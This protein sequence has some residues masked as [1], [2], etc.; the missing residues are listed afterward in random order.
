MTDAGISEITCADCSSP[1]PANAKFCLE[2][3]TPVAAAP[4]RE[5]RKTVTLLF[6]DVT[7][8][9]AM[10]EALDPETYRGVMG[11]YF[12]V[13]RTAVERH[14]GTVEKF[15]GDAV[16]AVF[17]VPDV[18]EDDALRAVR[19]ADELNAAIT[20]LSDELPAEPR[21]PLAIRT[22][23]NTGSVVAG[24]ARA[25]GS[26]ATGDAVNTA[27]RLEQAA[28]PGEILLGAA[29]WHLVRDAVDV[30]PVEPITP[31]ARPNRSRPTAC[32][33]SVPTRPGRRAPPRRADGRPEHETRALDDALERTVA[34][35]RSH[36]VTVLGPPG[37]GKSRLVTDFLDR[38]GDRA[39]VAQ[40]AVRLL[41]PGHHLLPGR[42]GHPRRAALSPATSPTRSC[43][44]RL[45]RPRA[46]ATDA[47]ES[48]TCCSPLLGRA[49]T[50]GQPRPDLSGPSA[51]SSRSSPPG[52]RW[53]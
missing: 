22:G 17:G 47:T 48:W 4:E 53:C 14:G 5:T 42:P 7:G 30:E 40:R 27:A 25:G 15:V 51:A 20:V 45:S 21:C 52:A 38:V 32:S 18:R 29:T 28:R 43:D 9:T 35:G 34:T 46:G 19:A 13:A 41:R 37:I 24:T 44:T 6:T 11:R 1:L 2:C 3:G 36:L 23:V 8:S 39:D 10:G 31:R 16:L 26:F 50:S 12:D 49:A 33:R